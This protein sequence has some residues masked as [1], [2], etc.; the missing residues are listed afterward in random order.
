LKLV[1]EKLFCVD[2]LEEMRAGNGIL[3]AVLLDDRA[4]HKAGGVQGKKQP[5][6]TQPDKKQLC[7]ELFTFF[8]RQLLFVRWL[9]Q[10]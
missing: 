10:L 6:M 3:G 4:I 7:V 5:C 1:H 2:S 9:I 8:A